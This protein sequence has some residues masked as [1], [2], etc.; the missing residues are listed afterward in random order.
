MSQ[1]SPHKKKLFSNTSNSLKTDKTIPDK[2]RLPIVIVSCL[3]FI[4][5]SACIYFAV[6]YYKIRQDIIIQN[7]QYSPAY[8]HFNSLTVDSFKEKV[9]SGEDMVV[10]I[11]RPNCSSCARLEPS[12]IEYAEAKGIADQIYLLN[13]VQLRKDEHEWELFKQNYG[14]LSGTPSYVRYSEGELV[15]KVIWP[16]EG[17]LTLKEIDMWI[18]AQDD[19]FEFG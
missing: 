7:T 13:V 15:S 16:E 4:V 8:F 6:N 14:E 19:Y 1:Y 12:F 9:A 5:T 3:F 17:E 2:S 10:L 11:S 18:M